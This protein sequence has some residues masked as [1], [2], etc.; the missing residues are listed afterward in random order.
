MILL[1]QIHHLTLVFGR[2]ILD[3]GNLPMLR[4]KDVDDGHH[5]IL[6][7]DITEQCLESSVGEDV[8]ITLNPRSSFIKILFHTFS[9]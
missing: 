8:N 4:K 2:Q 3:L 9:F 7:G 5:D 1:V 6:V